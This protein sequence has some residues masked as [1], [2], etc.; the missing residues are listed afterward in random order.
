MHSTVTQRTHILCI[1]NVTTIW[2]V[3]NCLVKSK[4]MSSLTWITFDDEVV[5][6]FKAKSM[7]I[8]CSLHDVHEM[9]AYGA[10][11]VCLST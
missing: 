2:P 6:H 3:N 4:A 1:A 10:G 5:L 8:M 9:N 11:H 7:L